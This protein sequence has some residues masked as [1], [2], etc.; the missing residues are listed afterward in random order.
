[1]HTT[2]TL[3]SAD[4]RTTAGVLLLTIVAVESGGWFMLR[5]LRG[6]HQVTGF[7]QAFFRA[8]HAHAGVLVTLALVGTLLAD[9]ANLSGLLGTVARNGIPGAAVLM[10]A[11]FFLSASGR[12]VIRPNRMIVLL[13]LGMVSLAAGVIALGVGLLR[14]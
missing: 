6:G 1:M 13:Y 9:S 5:V 8:G 7:Q 3:L 2:A 10:S 11:G 4:S 12:E 14:A